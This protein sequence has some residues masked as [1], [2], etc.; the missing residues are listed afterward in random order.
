M[1]L[2]IFN[3]YDSHSQLNWST[4]IGGIGDDRAF[5]IKVDKSG[6]S[7]ITGQ[8]YSN[9][10]PIKTG[11]YRD[12]MKGSGDIFVTKLNSIGKNLFFSTFIGSNES[13]IGYDIFIDKFGNSYLTGNSGKSFA[14]KLNST[15]SALIYFKE[16]GTGKSYKIASDSLGNAYICGSAN[17]SSYPVTTGTFDTVYNGGAD[18]AV[19]T[20]LK[21]NG[22]SLIYSTF[23]GGAGDDQ[24]YGLTINSTGYLFVS[25]YTNSPDFPVT[26]GVLNTSHEGDENYADVFLSKLNPD[27][28]FLNYSSLI[29]GNINDWAYS[30]AIDNSENT[31]ITGLTTSINFP[32]SPGAYDKIFNGGDDVFVSKVNPYASLIVYSTFIGGSNGDGAES[33]VLDKN[34]NVYITGI[35]WSTNF[36]VTL[37]AFDKSN[38]SPYYNCFVSKIKA[39]GSK[40]L[41]STYLGGTGIN[42]GKDIALDSS[43]S[44]IMTGYTSSDDFPV[45]NDSYDTS[46]NGDNDVFVTNLNIGNGE[47][48][49]SS[50]GD[51]TFPLLLCYPSYLDSTLTIIN[52]GTAF[53]GLTGARLSGQDS[54]DFSIIEPVNMPIL[55][56]PYDSVKFI[57]RFTPSKPIGTEKT[58]LV[59]SNNSSKSQYIINLTARKDSISFNV[60]SLDTDTI[61]IDLGTICPDNKKD[62]TITIFNKSSIGTTLHIENNDPKIQ[63]TPED[64][65]GKGK[66]D[67]P[68]GVKPKK[69]KNEK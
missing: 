59:I 8:T 7:F 45:T 68:Q 23:L 1:I 3:Y 64:K 51:L 35:T 4:F 29:G 46:Y 48:N 36:P 42:Y 44:V 60:D 11:A 40:L 58:T 17:S 52:T 61:F 50:S 56:H 38:N 28:N 32:V 33:L 47:P 25:G 66:G 6:N 57:I 30:I 18:D 65:A 53:L 21:P 67:V 39:D 19:I 24:A 43:I 2:G 16:I 10:Y 49:I 54:S 5:G 34:N 27:G 22:K 20:K 31:Y 9:D 15:G 12:S 63:I 62:T 69:M 26:V 55:I 41:Y 13:D 14:A 37:D